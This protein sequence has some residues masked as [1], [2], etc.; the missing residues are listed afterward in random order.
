M[1]AL[2]CWLVQQA[3]RERLGVARK[4]TDAQANRVLHWFGERIVTRRGSRYLV[5]LSATGERW[6]R[7]CDHEID[8]RCAFLAEKHEFWGKELARLG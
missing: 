6:L 8:R 7:M 4:M 1:S 3:H 5:V 2:P